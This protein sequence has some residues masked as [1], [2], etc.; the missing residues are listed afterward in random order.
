MSLAATQPE[1]PATMAGE[2]SARAAT[3]LVICARNQL[4]TNTLA[5]TAALSARNAGLKGC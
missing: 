4:I 3:R 2:L 5:M 1:V